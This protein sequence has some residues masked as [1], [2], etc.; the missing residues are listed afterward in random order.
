MTIS[1]FL[2]VLP[3]VLPHFAIFIIFFIANGREELCHATTASISIIIVSI[4]I[5]V[6]ASVWRG[7]IAFLEQYLKRAK[8]YRRKLS[9]FIMKDEGNPEIFMKP[10]RIRL[11]IVDHDSAFNNSN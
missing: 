5:N 3:G 6:L 7:G 1:H 9:P 10:N 4:P 2:Q 11:P 8:K